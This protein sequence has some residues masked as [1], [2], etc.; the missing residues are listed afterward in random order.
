MQEGNV[1]IK[2][3]CLYGSSFSNFNIVVSELMSLD[4]GEY[5]E[6][7]ELKEKALHDSS[8]GKL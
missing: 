3:R 5:V 8:I 4:F 6:N 1:G 2:Y 7:K